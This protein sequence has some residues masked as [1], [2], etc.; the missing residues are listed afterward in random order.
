[1]LKTVRLAEMVEWYRTVVG[2]VPNFSFEG[3]AWTTNDEAHHSVAFLQTPALS[4]PPSWPQHWPRVCRSKSCRS[5]A[6]AYQAAAPADL[7]LPV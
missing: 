6:G 5:R 7:R 3:G 1:M 4:A 2:C